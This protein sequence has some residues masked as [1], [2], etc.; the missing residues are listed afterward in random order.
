MSPAPQPPRDDAWERFV[1]E[2]GHRAVGRDIAFIL[3]RP[4][5]EIDR[6][7]AVGV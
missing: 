1:V 7:R 3:G 6:L 4:V 2:H 5:E